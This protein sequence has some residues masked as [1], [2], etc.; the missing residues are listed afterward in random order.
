VLALTGAVRTE[1]IAWLKPLTAEI[2]ESDAESVEDKQN[3]VGWH[4]AAAL[5]KK[6]YTAENPGGP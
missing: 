1:A 6:E 4:D 5:E 2:A 3:L